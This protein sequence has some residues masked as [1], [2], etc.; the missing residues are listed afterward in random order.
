MLDVLNGVDVAVDV[1]IAVVGVDGS[2]EL[3][4]VGHPHSP[5]LF[6]GTGFVGDYPLVDGTIVDG[7]D[8]GGLAALGVDHGPDGAPVAIDLWL[9]AGGCWLLADNSE[10]TRGEIAHGTLH[11]RLDVEARVLCR[12][13]LH[14]DGQSRE[15]PRSLDGHE[16]FHAEATVGAVEVGG[17]EHVVAQVSHKQATGEVAMERFGHKL[18][19]SYFIHNY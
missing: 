19:G 9:L 2:L 17:I 1:D 7:V 10:I 5:T 15:Y 14:L 6:Y 12:H 13:L 4:P 11:P 8:V 3:C 16:V 18:V